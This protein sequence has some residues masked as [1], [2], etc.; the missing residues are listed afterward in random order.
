VV[1]PVRAVNDVKQLNF[2]PGPLK[3]IM[4]DN[5]WRVFKLNERLK[6]AEPPK[7]KRTAG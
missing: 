6:K 4:R 5:A 3:K 2:R 7:R 1:D